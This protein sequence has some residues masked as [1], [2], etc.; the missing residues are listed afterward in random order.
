MATANRAARAK[1]TR[2]LAVYRCQLVEERK[3]AVPRRRVRCGG[4]AAAILLPY[5]AKADREHFVVLLLDAENVALGINTVAVGTPR[6]VQVC[7]REVLKPALLCNADRIV[8]AHNHVNGNVAPSAADRK[9]TRAIARAAD[10]LGVALVDHVV[11]GRAE[12][13]SFRD[14]GLL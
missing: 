10:V 2:L 4:D 5:L 12:F 8:V 14:R 11:V 1:G 13:Y 6:S 9:I 3:I 7:C